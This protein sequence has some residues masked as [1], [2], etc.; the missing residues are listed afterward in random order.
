[1]E[2][3]GNKTNLIGKSR[4][5][6]MAFAESLGE[7]PF[8]G[9]QI[10][11]WLYGRNAENF[12]E[13]TSLAANLRLRLDEV[14]AIDTLQVVQRQISQRRDAEKFLFALHDGLRLESVLMHEGERHTL[15]VS[16]QVGCPIDCQF[17]ATGKMGLLRNLTAGEIINQFLTV[18][19]LTQQ[20][21]TNV[22]VMGMGEPMLNYDELIK[23]CTILSD[24]EGPNLAQKHIVISTSGLIPKI[25][26]YMEEGHKFRLAI[27]L[28]ATTDEVRNRLMPLNRKWPIADLLAAA[29]EY[30]LASKQLVTFEYVL[31]AGV[32]DSVEDAKRL[33]RLLRDIPCKVNLIPFN[34]VDENFQRPSHDKVEAFYQQLQGM[35]AP[36]MI[37][38]S[39]GDDID[40]A[41]GQLWTKAEKASG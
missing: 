37:R 30:A 35:E 31:L 23:A 17:C 29:K 10:F 22:V 3:P 5:E 34:A 6:L 41:C 1:M 33:K 24:A 21:I 26:R 32:N 38:W 16:S 36:V 27:S 12:S 18:R 2:F 4:A 20:P 15:C 8:R 7:K 19:R 13:M 25:R 11:Q 9:K 40:A 39:K 28:N 14:A